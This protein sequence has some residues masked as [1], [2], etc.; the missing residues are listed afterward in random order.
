M[1]MKDKLKNARISKGLTQ[2]QLSEKVGAAQASIN[3]LESG[4]IKN[5]SFELAVKIANTLETN[6]F[7]IFGNE[8]IKNY[9]PKTNESEKDQLK[10]LA[11]YALEKYVDTKIYFRQL[12]YDEKLSPEEHWNIHNEFL[13]Q[14]ESFKKGLLEAFV[15]VGFCNQEEMSEINEH[16]KKLKKHIFKEDIKP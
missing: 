10:L 9:T 1:E 11:V 14:I 5:P 3:K 8:N 13:I 12:E 15:M 16:L 4:K 2:L 7:E 6:V